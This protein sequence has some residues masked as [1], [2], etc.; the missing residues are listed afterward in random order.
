[1]PSEHLVCL[2][3][4]S[5]IS[6]PITARRIRINQFED[7]SERCRNLNHQAWP[8]VSQ[9][10]FC[11]LQHLLCTTPSTQANHLQAIPCRSDKFVY[12][13]KFWAVNVTTPLLCMCHPIHPTGIL[14][15]LTV[16]G[17]TKMVMYRS[18]ALAFLPRHMLYD[19]FYTA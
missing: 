18:G 11:H 8:E 15:E 9:C 7:E 1:M 19:I 2:Q 14:N 6:E 13:I 12:S 17:V 4:I 3:N 16:S 5:T 10:S